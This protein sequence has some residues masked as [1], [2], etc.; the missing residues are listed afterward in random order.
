[1]KRNSIIVNLLLLVIAIVVTSCADSGAEQPKPNPVNIS[2]FIDLSDRIE[3]S[4][5][6]IQQDTLIV[7]EAV[8]YFTDATIH[9]NVGLQNSKNIIKVI[10]NPAPAGDIINVAAD[11]LQIDLPTLPVGKEKLHKVK[12]ARGTFTKSLA[13]VYSNAIQYGKEHSWPGSDLWGFF[14]N[15]VVDQQC[16]KDGYRNVL[17]IITDGEV[18]YS[19][20]NK[21]V[22]GKP[23]FVSNDLLNNPNGELLVEREA[24]LQNLEVMILEI[25]PRDAK[26][27]PRMKQVLENWLMGM[28]VKKENICLYQTDTPANVRTV[29]GKFLKKS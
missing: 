23:N 2:I 15:G 14:N 4:P 24:N 10:F 8:N 18:F 11:K 20:I 13:D 16:V 25:N 9:S 28:G 1:M 3:A 27:L 19:P 21:T 5:M 22:N 12:D 6:Q 7:G 26:N 29:I 17:V